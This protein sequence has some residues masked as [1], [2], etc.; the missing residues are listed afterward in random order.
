MS[1]AALPSASAAA[2]R[3]FLASILALRLFAR[4]DGGG[5]ADMALLRHGKDP[6]NVCQKKNEP[7]GSRIAER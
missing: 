6:I 5:A 3:A 7:R 1:Y 2:R 4:A